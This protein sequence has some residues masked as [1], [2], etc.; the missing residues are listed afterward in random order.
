MDAFVK[1][2]FQKAIVNIGNAY[3]GL[4]FWP[5]NL[6]L[7][8][9]PDAAWRALLYLGSR[10]EGRFAGAAR[11]M[12]KAKDSRV[13][14]WA[15][16]ALGQCQDEQS[17]E[18][19]YKLNADPSN[20][21]RIHAWQALQVLV[22][23]EESARHFPVRVP[24]REKLILISEDSKRM[25]SQLSA[26]LKRLGFLIITAS[27]EQETIALALRAKP[28]AIITDNQKGRGRDNLSGLNMTWD[29]CRHPALRETV[30]FMLSADRIEPVFLWNGGDYFLWKKSA[31][32]DALIKVV[33][34][35]LHH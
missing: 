6:K 20:R 24:T 9:N 22:G 19:I 1:S 14:A 33:M 2:R 21:V 15:C 11:R 10:R 5:E 30:I 8:A 13:R 32:L 27:T 34:E 16:Y 4:M 25:Q 31:R 12:L 23:P 35:Y 7:Q 28:Q 18:Q 17:V 26:M 3:G 29:I